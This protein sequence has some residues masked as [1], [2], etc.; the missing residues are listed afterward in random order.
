MNIL[1]I[2]ERLQEYLSHLLKNW[3]WILLFTFSVASLML[4]HGL[5]K[6]P[7]VTARATF[8]PTSEKGSAGIESGLTQFFGLPGQEGSELTY[9]KGLLTSRSLNR[10]LVA[11]TIIF[12]GEKRLLA[13]LLLEYSPRFT[14]LPSRIESWTKPPLDLEKLGINQKI[15]R[16]ANAAQRSLVISNTETGFGMITV[17]FYN[18]VITSILCERYLVLLQRYYAE[19]KARK[20]NQQL[21]FLARRADSLKRE[22]DTANYKI[23][24]YREGGRF[25]I[26]F[27]DE[28]TPAQLESEASLLS[29]MYVSLYASQEQARAQLQR[30]LPVVQVID[31]PMPPFPTTRANLL[32][33]FMIGLFLGLGLSL[34]LF[35]FP[36]LRRDL[37][38]LV[39]TQVLE[40]A[41][42]QR[43]NEEQSSPSEG[44]E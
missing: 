2:L 37:I 13:D 21:Q 34:V 18:P 3:S 8:H 19:Q 29:Q 25:N 26:R 41:R 5:S 1:D 9:M 43:A 10:T 12:K 36:L 42:R 15:H 30:D 27:R 40:P 44:L 11:D 23:A 7:F 16:A 32:L 20:G 33:H 31:P 22:L 35:S 4:L 38:T 17:S 6:P 24:R 14:S 28:I 39:N